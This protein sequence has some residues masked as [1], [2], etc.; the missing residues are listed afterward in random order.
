MRRRQGAEWE[1]LLE[2]VSPHIAAPTLPWMPCSWS[3]L[4]CLP[5]RLLATLRS[6]LTVDKHTRPNVGW[7]DRTQEDGHL[8]AVPEAGQTSGSSAAEQAVSE[9]MAAQVSELPAA[10]QCNIASM[11]FIALLLILGHAN[12]PCN[13]RR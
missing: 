12:A 5:A 2:A 6:H 3:G 1:A 7:L 9:A 8:A 4:R 11:G 10:G 13:G